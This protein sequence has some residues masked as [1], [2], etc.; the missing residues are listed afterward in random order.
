MQQARQL[1]APSILRGAFDTALSSTSAGQSG[2]DTATPWE[3]AQLKEHAGYGSKSSRSR[4]AAL[5]LLEQALRGLGVLSPRVADA[6]AALQRGAGDVQLVAETGGSPVQAADAAMAAHVV[7]LAMGGSSSPT[8]AAI[9][10]SEP[11]PV[12]LP[13]LELTPEQVKVTRYGLGAVAPELWNGEALLAEREQFYDWM[14]ADIQLDRA[15]GVEMSKNERCLALRCC[16]CS[17]LACRRAG[18]VQP[19]LSSCLLQ[20]LEGYTPIHQCSPG[21]LPHVLRH[22]WAG[23]V[24]FGVQG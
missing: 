23:A 8:A 3:V 18:T 1:L 16:L 14:T 4:V 21:L 10:P 5:P 17:W 2:T 13:A 22:S 9:D 11:I 6:F 7:G 20:E 19:T 15:S 12:R 24:L